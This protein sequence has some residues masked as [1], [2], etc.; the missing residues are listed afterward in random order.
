MITQ[1]S[2]GFLSTLALYFSYLLQPQ[3]APPSNFFCTCSL[4]EPFHRVFNTVLVT[5]P[6]I[7]ALKETRS[8]V[9]TRQYHLLASAFLHSPLNFWGRDVAAF[10]PALRLTSTLAWKFFPQLFWHVSCQQIQMF[11]QNNYYLC[12]IALVASSHWAALA[13]CTRASHVQAQCHDV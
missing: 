7:K 4:R 11:S 1:Y 6:S 10:M 9:P 8:T 2:S 13:R 5:W 3:P 12:C